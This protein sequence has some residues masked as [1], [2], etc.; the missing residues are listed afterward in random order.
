M[1]F[2]LFWEQVRQERA[3]EPSVHIAVTVSQY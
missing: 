1:L 2:I 3:E